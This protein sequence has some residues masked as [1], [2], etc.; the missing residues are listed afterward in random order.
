MNYMI[1][2]SKPWIDEEEVSRVIRQLNS[3]ALTYS[4]TES[5]GVIKEFEKELEKFL[6]VKNVVTVNSGTSA[7][8]A[9]LIAFGVGPGDEVILQSYSF[10][11]AA[12]MV[13]LLGAK[14]IFVDI[15]LDNYGISVDD[16]KK[17]ITPKTKL[18][19]ITHLYGYPSK[20]KE[21]NEIANQKS[22]LI[23]EDCAQALGS[24]FDNKYLGTIGFNGCFSFYP[25][26]LI[27]TG[28]GGCISTNQDE[29][30]DKIKMIR[31]H[32][33]LRNSETER[34]GLNLRLPSLL[35]VIGLAQMKKIDK[36][37]K[38][39][40]EIAKCISY[41]IKELPLIY[42]KETKDTVFNW[43]Y[44][45]VRSK[46][47]NRNEII[48]KLNKRGIQARAYYSKPIH[49]MKLYEREVYSDT[50]LPNTEEASRTAFSLPIYPGLK[51]EQVKEINHALGEI[52]NK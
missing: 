52:F 14:P 42:P 1:P 32:G 22:I 33:I 9:S 30:A 21:I 40:Q 25:S 10:Q 11:A 44:Y 49:E 23:M 18:I 45:T 46:T 41:E 50:R 51:L 12:N 37:L 24:M 6:N 20:I 48:S 7:I 27:A 19:I 3:G 43:N 26:K 34:I 13:M 29:F 16:L 36:I 38:A 31:N 28:E 39:R 15:E 47:I 5:Q 17:N 2:I 4:D 35:S 8:L